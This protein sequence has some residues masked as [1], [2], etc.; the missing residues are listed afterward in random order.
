MILID[1]T[2]IHQDVINEAFV[3]DL[4]KC[5]GACCWE[6]EYGAPLEKSEINQIEEI[7]EIVLD[8]LTQENRQ[9][10]KEKG[11]S[12]WY[13]DLNKNGTPLMGD[14]ACAFLI[15][16][17]NGVGKCAFEKVWEEGKTNFKKPISCHLYPIRISKSEAT[18]MEFVNYDRWKICNPACSLGA[19]LKIPLFE[20]CSEA[21]ER[22]Y[23][24]EFLEKLRAVK[25][26]W[27]DEDKK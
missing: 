13:D 7:L 2:L 1:N 24:K 23:G 17:G 3:C 6:G 22:K 11:V 18:D 8:E 16:E 12:V 5:Q 19:K 21:L 25:E 14:G 15:R 27:S 26:E 4:N 9:I 10:I 20:F